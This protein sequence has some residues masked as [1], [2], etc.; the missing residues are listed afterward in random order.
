MKR[1]ISLISA[2][3]TDSD[4]RVIDSS[5][6]DVAIVGT[7]TMEPFLTPLKRVSIPLVFDPGFD[8]EGFT[9]QWNATVCFDTADRLGYTP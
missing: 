9:A 4:V 1:S 5:D 8:P 6:D 7:S 2:A 3:S